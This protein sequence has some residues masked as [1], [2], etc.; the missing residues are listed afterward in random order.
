MEFQPEK[1]KGYDA[2]TAENIIDDAYQIAESLD[3]EYSD[4]V[5]NAISLIESVPYAVNDDGEVSSED[6]TDSVK[7]VAEL[8]EAANDLREEY[9]EF[10]LEEYSDVEEDEKIKLLEERS[11][12]NLDYF[13]KREMMGAIGSAVVKDVLGPV[14]NNYKSGRISFAT[15]NAL[16]GVEERTDIDDQKLLMTAEEGYAVF[17]N[18]EY[19]SED[20]EELATRNNP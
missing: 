2:I 5:E 3:N 20:L 6:L 15:V 17:S 7:G 12:E 8:W 10:K 19:T 11:E 9:D 13:E 14:F 16:E 1:L 18:K 4:R